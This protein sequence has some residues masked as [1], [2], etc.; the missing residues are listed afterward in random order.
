VSKNKQHVDGNIEIL[1]TR[2]YVDSANKTNHFINCEK[3][4]CVYVF[5]SVVIVA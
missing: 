1:L 5:Q 4:E 2:F 3:L